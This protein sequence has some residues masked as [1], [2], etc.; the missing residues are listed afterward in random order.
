[1]YNAEV[2]CKFPVVQHFPFGSLFSW[3]EDPNAPPLTASAHLSPQTH[4]GAMSGSSGA[5][6][7]SR[8]L[9]QEGTRAQWDQTSSTSDSGEGNPINHPVPMETIK[10]PWASS[11]PT[12]ATSSQAST[13]RPFLPQEGAKAPWA[14]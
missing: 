13:S 14:R 7:A 6:H 9:P 4:S 12:T 10:A 11:G 2:L 5:I 8:P 3:E 1:M